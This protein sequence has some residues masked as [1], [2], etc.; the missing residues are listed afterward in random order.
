MKKINILF[1]TLI[2]CGLTN[3]SYAHSEHST[4][5]THKEMLQSE[6]GFVNCDRHA[7]V[8][9]TTVYHYSNGTRRISSVESIITTSGS[10]VY[11]ITPTVE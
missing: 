2:V 3:F 10:E 6:H 7:M 8:K 9:D 5:L 11:L 4:Y 1:V